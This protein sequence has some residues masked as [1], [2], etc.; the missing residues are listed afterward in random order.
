MLGGGLG[1]L[2]GEFG[3]IETVKSRTEAQMKGL[4]GFTRAVVVGFALFAGGRFLYENRDR[5]KTEWERV[6]SVEDIKGFIGDLS[7]GKLLESA[8]S[9]RK[10]A[11]QF[12]Q[13]KH[14]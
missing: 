7:I 12:S 10:L 6:N 4:L 9:I 5:L 14:S 1:Y 13:L 11:N 2:P 8:G 3:Q